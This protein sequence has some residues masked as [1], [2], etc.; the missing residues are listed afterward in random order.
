MQ[1]STVQTDEPSDTNRQL[2]AQ[3]A[4]LLTFEQRYVSSDE[5]DD[6]GYHSVAHL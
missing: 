1:L 6:I 2:D 5:E 4:E 3:P